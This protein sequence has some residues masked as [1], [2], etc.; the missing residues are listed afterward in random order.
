MLSHACLLKSFQGSF[1]T[2]HFCTLFCKLT[3]LAIFKSC[4][5]QGLLWRKRPI[6]KN[7]STTFERPH[8]RNANAQDLTAGS[9]RNRRV[10]YRSV[11][12]EVAVCCCMLMLSDAHAQRRQFKKSYLFQFKTS[13]LSIVYEKTPYFFASLPL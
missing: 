5:K 3:S 6:E 8:I 2:L 7:I 10:A 4:I 1:L 11:I 9:A 13:W 12:P